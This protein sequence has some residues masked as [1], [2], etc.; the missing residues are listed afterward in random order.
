MGRMSDSLKSTVVVSCTSTPLIITKIGS[1]YSSFLLAFISACS[2][3]FAFAQKEAPALG[4][5]RLCEVWHP[6]VL[7][8]ELRF[9]LWEKRGGF[10]TVWVFFEAGFLCRWCLE[11]ARQ[12]WTCSEA[13]WEI[14]GG[15]KRKSFPHTE[16]ISRTILGI[17]WL[18]C[19]FF[20]FTVSKLLMN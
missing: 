16:G 14:L 3:W 13:P 5:P 10:T 6:E 19:V 4:R 11:N 18:V 20:F 8:G 15:K 1:Q 12:V 17:G 2:T 7:G 9:H